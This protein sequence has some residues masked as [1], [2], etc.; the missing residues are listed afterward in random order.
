MQNIDF[1]LDNSIPLEKGKLL[2]SEPFLQDEFF[3]RSV[4][5]LCEHNETGSFGFVLNNYVE[6][7]L[8]EISKSFINNMAK[9]S[10]GGPVKKD[11]LFFIHTLGDLIPGSFHITD[12]LY[13]GGDHELLIEEIKENPEWIDQVRFFLGYSGW[14]EGQLQAELDEKN[15]L[16]V[17]NVKTHQIMDTK[18]DDFWKDIMSKQSEKHKIISQF[19]LDPRLN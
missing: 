3:T 2:L 15:W 12:T 17:D 16:V 19:P 18:N 11:N 13:L 1:N 9:I 8:K 14:D 6:F 5:L 10:L 4:I 7:S